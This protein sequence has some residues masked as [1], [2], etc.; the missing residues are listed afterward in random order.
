M[1]ETK[2]INYGGGVIWVTPDRISA[3][4]CRGNQEGPFYSV[5]EAME[6]IDERNDYI[7]QCGKNN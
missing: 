4:D 1:A 2:K 7:A 3:A 6:W 5:N